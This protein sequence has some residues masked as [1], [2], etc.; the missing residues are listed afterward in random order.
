MGTTL[1]ILIM[2]I[3]GMAISF[4]IGVKVGYTRG[5]HQ[6]SRRGFARGIS[7]SRNLVSEINRAA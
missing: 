3:V 5:D 7:V 2:G 4:M 6:G 1:S